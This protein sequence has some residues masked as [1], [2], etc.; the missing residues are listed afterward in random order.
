MWAGHES[1]ERAEG[2][3]NSTLRAIRH[4]LSIRP[5]CSSAYTR[6]RGNRPR[7]PGRVTGYLEY[8]ISMESDGYIGGESAS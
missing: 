5:S 1:L 6:A 7:A 3:A 2:L 4:T 8:W